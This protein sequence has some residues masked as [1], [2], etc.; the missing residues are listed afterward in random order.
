MLLQASLSDCQNVVEFA[1][2]LFGCNSPKLA[3]LSHQHSQKIRKRRNNEKLCEEL[4]KEQRI[5]QTKVPKDALGKG[6]MT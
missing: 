1:F 6:L 5:Y 2:N 3:S 4:S